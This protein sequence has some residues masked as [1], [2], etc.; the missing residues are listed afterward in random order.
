VLLLRGISRRDPQPGS[1]EASHSLSSHATSPAVFSDVL[2]AIDA[3]RTSLRAVSRACELLAPDARMTV[4]VCTHET[5]A[6]AWASADVSAA[7]A[8]RALTRA[9]EMARQAGLRGETVLDPDGPPID[10]VLERAAS[11]PLLALGAPVMP[12]GAG[13]WVGGVALHAVHHLP[14]SLLIARERPLAAGAHILLAL[15]GTD[16]APGLPM[17]AAYAARRLK[18][19]VVVVH[20]VGVESRSQ[21]HHLEAQRDRLAGLL[22]VAPEMVI[23]AK[24][25]AEAI[26]A[27]ARERQT[28][29]IIMGSRRIGGVRALSSVSERVA[30]RARCSVLVIR[31][32][33]QGS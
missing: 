11:H 22:G 6:G 29:L 32:E 31:P 9:A 15:D 26:L 5:G 20:A 18:R 27:V 28:S 13:L 33:E 16:D 1:P 17:I 3:S 4:L 2:C 12:R 25:P 21:P 14:S 19:G 23:E 24:R 30:H 7:R 10:R 8:R